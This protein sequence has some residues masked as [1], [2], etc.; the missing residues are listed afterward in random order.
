MSM[1]IGDIKKIGRKE[2]QQQQTQSDYDNIF[3]YAVNS[4][5]SEAV[6]RHLLKDW[7]KYTEQYH[8][9]EN[10][11]IYNSCVLSFNGNKEHD[12]VCYLTKTNTTISELRKFIDSKLE[13]LEKAQHKLYN[14]DL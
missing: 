14:I 9:Y 4:T 6:Y 5:W 11:Y 12:D 13:E 1:S 8:I 3:H 7:D 2:K 10:Y